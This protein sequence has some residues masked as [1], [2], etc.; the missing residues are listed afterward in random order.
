VIHWAWLIPAYVA[1]IATVAAAL[2]FVGIDDE[3]DNAT[4]ARRV[5]DEVERKK[6][7]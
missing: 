6:D 4:L 1:G 5:Y 2:R 3:I 7:Q